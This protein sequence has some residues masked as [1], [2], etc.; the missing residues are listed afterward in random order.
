MA[1]EC[2]DCAA[3]LC[4]KNKSGRCRSCFAKLRAERARRPRMNCADCEKVLGVN[5]KTGRCHPCGNRWRWA[6]DYNALRER[7]VA[8]IRLKYDSDPDYRERVARACRRTSQKTSL[9]PVLR[10]ARR[11]QWFKTYNEHL[12]TPEG[13]EKNRKAVSEKSGKTQVAR[14]FAWCPPEFREEYRHLIRSKR[15]RAVDAR[16][17]VEAKI[18]D[19]KALK[20]VS[21]ALEHLKRLAPVRVLENGY[22]YGNAILRPSEV[23][24]R[25]KLR[26]WQPERWAA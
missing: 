24:E 5:N 11:E 17:I 14:R 3:S 18:A 7:Q 9:D 10:A 23:I 20:H 8:G 12:N 1:S 21:S 26:G 15:M 4:V 19:A 16:A 25:A 6:N 13:R 2:L 22:Q